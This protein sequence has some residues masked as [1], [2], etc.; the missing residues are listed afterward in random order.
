MEKQPGCRTGNPGVPRTLTG[1]HRIVA[2]HSGHIRGMSRV[3]RAMRETELK[4]RN[5]L[6]IVQGSELRL[7]T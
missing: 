3:R 1:N 4:S 7:D 5:V 2:H 6:G